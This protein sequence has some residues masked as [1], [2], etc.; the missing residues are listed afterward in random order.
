VRE[1]PQVVLVAL[2]AVALVVDVRHDPPSLI[3]YQGGW[4]V[5]GHSLV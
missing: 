3:E 1:S 5:G 4:G 2:H